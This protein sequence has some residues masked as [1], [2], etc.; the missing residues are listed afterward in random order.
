MTRQQCQFHQQ[1]LSMLHSAELLKKVPRP[2][3]LMTDLGMIHKQRSLRNRNCEGSC[4][5]FK[6]KTR[7]FAPTIFVN[8]F[9]MD[10][11][12]CSIDQQLIGWIIKKK[13]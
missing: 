12:K 9:R 10:K 8:V 13:G 1:K 2:E 4:E 5:S 3:R 6:D 11:C 7:T